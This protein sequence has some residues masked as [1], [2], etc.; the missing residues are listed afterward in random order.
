M[1]KRASKKSMTDMFGLATGEGYTMRTNNGEVVASYEDS[2][3]TTYV[4]PQACTSLF[5][6][7]DGLADDIIITIDGMAFTIRT[8]EGLNEG[9]APFSEVTLTN[10]SNE[11]YRMWVRK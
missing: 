1:G 11:A 5:F 3:S 7:N 2:L 9:F 10:T 6:I 8:E 4:L